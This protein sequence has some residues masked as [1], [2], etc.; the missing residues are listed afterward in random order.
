MDIVTAQ[1]MYEWDRAALDAAG[2]EG[3]MLMES[4]GRA[5]ADDMVHHIRKQD[6]VI[7]LI[8][9]GNNG[10][11]GF[12]IARTLLNRGYD[13]E[14]WQVV[15]DEKITGD[16][17]VHKDIFVA[18]GFSVNLYS[19]LE[20]LQLSFQNA[21]IIIDAM[22]GIGVKGRLRTPIAEIV[23]AANGHS[24][25][26]MAVDLPSGVPADEGI[27]DFDAFH[28]DYTTVIAAPKMSAFLQHSRPYYGD[29]C[30]VEIGLPIRKLPPVN[31]GLWRKEDVRRT[32]PVRGENS[33]KGSHGKGVMV[34]GS[35]LMPGSIAMAG[36]AALRSGVG[37]LTI[38]TVERAI[39]SISPYLQEA[40]FVGMEEEECALTGQATDQLSGYDGIAVG[41]GMG[42]KRGAKRLLE[43]IVQE[44][45][46]PM[47]IDADGLY[48]L[49]EILD[50]VRERKSPTVLTPHPGEFAHLTGLSIQDVLQ[51]PFSYSRE[52]AAKYGVYLVLKGPSTIITSPD[53][54]QRV[55]VSGN[56]G[57][58][59]G[60]S[61]D[62]L[63]GVL[64]AM[65]LQS[66]S[67]L[68]ALSNGCVIHG[69]T[70]ES[71]TEEKHSKRDLLASDVIEGLSRTFR[72]ISSASR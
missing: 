14:A 35:L 68:D 24:V 32:L 20:E 18:S 66:D 27:V 21:D 38:A 47:L 41:M 58:A 39:S 52:F 8:G 37:L 71:L 17:R 55:D 28:A 13:I 63:S 30:I 65:M 15:P 70:A 6:K 4:A 48:H 57:L 61:G 51:S 3:K 19:S 33:H 7:V 43:V 1:E 45:E 67:L 36:R 12:V 40:T 54:E 69:C 9:S 50:V 5:V 34:G 29:Y 42:R 31:R 72:T 60:G 25:F 23:E 2:I 44:V 11:D 10:G 22:V 62:V 49:K 16:A 53:G 59:K 26:R 56:A 64:F 46:A